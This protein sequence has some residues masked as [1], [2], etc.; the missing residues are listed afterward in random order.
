[1]LLDDRGG[2]LCLARVALRLGLAGTFAGGYA[3]AVGIVGARRAAE[4]AID[5]LRADTGF[6][7]CRQRGDS[8]SIS[9][10][11][12]I[13]D[14]LKRAFERDDPRGIPDSHAA[15]RNRVGHDS[16]DSDEDIVADCQGANHGGARP[17][18]DSVADYRALA[19]GLGSSAAV[20]D[21]Y[22]LREGAMM[23]KDD[24]R[25][26]HNIAGMSDIESRADRSSSRK[27]DIRRHAHPQIC[28]GGR[29]AQQFSYWAR[30]LGSMH[31][32]REAIPDDG[33]Y[34]RQK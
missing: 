18:V 27:L 22:S 6:V 4:S 5:A 3:S 12:W 21:R 20:S 19:R 23:S 31:P 28:Q 24:A 10:H 30:Q 32:T 9:L 13:R 2:E 17:Y 25:A 15:R 26:Q 7:S 14:K 33:P 16:V 11:P 1:L 29:H 34:Y 8:L